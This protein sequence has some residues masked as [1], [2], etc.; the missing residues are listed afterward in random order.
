MV[1]YLL[2]HSQLPI[3]ASARVGEVARMGIPFRKGQPKFKAA[4][5]GALAQLQADGSLKAMSAK[6][7]GTD[8]SR[9]AP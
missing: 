6:W 1:A 2:K 8:A 5:D 9:P 7:F 3:K 4:I